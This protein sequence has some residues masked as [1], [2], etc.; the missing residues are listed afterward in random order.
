MLDGVVNFFT[1]IFQAIG[2]GIGR[3]VAALLW[4]FVAFGR[5]WTRHGWLARGPVGIFLV[6]LFGLYGYFLYN[7]IIW[8]G[9]DVDYPAA[10]NL[11]NRNLSAGEQ[12]PAAGDGSTTRSCGRSAIADTT[13]D[14]IDY[15]VNEN[16]WVS[17]M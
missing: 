1:R 8:R 14:L 16:G 11:T 17:S 9:F 15:N 4:P 5:W 13:I 2:R 6:V 10:Y 12:V 7:T 3:A